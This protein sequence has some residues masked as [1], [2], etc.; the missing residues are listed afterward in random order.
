MRDLMLDVGQANE[1]K[2]AFRRADYTN[3]DIKSLCEGKV[4]EDVRKVLRGHAAICL[5]KHV[6]D[7]DIGPFVPKF[8]SVEAHRMG[9]RFTWDESKVELWLANIQQSVEGI[10]GVTLLHTELAG[11]PVLNATALEFLLNN[12][13]LVPMEW[14]GKTVV[15][16]G[17]IFRNSVGDKLVRGMSYSDEFGGWAGCA[18]GLDEIW[19]S[20]CP[21]ALDKS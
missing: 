20:D 5:P 2:L 18:K 10:K 21:A 1:L 15:F 16:W 19:H 17:T 14:R 13:H 8:W 11:K 9:G 6:I 12:Q 7:C 4:L 3:G